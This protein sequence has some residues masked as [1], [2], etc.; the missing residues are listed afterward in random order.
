MGLSIRGHM[1]Y[2][3]MGY[4]PQQ[5]L[6]SGMRLSPQLRSFYQFHV[7]FTVRLILHKLGGIQSESALS[8]DPTFKQVDNIK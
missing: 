4:W 6:T 8:G 5:L 7:Y 1:G 3:N 2:W